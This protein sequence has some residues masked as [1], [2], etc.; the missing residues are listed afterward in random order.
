MFISVVI[1]L[2]NKEKSIQ[3]TIES[4]LNQSFQDFEILIIDDGSTDHSA[5]IVSGFNN[6]K[7]RYIKKENGGPSSARNLGVKKA[8]GDW[9]Y[10]LDADDLMECNTL[11]HF[12]GLI[13]ENPSINV[14]ASNF[15]IKKGRLF[16]KQSIYMKNGILSN[17][18]RSWFFGTLR[19][20]Q[21]AVI[22]KKEVLLQYPFPEYL[23]RWEDGA[24]F[25]EV[26]RNEKIYTSKTP[27]FIYNLDSASGSHGRKDIKE[28]YLGYLNPEGK[29][30][31]ERMDLQLLYTQAKELYPNQCNELY[32]NS[33]IGR[34]EGF[35]FDLFMACTWG[36]RAFAKLVNII[37]RL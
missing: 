36:L 7:I 1:P 3:N 6:Q 9:I 12:A 15:Y 27:L 26:M 29:S 14:F 35:L 10:F 20:C 2:F 13:N 11:L 31:W 16:K 4:V 28:D 24:M 33:L 8:S 21:G 30:F 18:Y 17:N 32:G 37:E 25:F 19:P 22:Y 34:K 23:R 5:K